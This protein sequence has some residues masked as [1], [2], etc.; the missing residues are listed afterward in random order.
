MN[1]DQFHR[2]VARATGESLGTIARR[3]FIMLTR[4]PFERES[5]G[6]NYE[7]LLQALCVPSHSQARERDAA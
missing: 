6:A 7:D 1:H 5:S 2:A 3:G 4:G